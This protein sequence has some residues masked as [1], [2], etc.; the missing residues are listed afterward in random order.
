MWFYIT[1]DTKKSDKKKL[2][3]LEQF[4]HAKSK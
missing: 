2:F 1:S 4:K 3:V